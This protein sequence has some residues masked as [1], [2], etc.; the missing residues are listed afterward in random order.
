[1]EN[2]HDSVKFWCL[3]TC[4]VISP[5]TW[6]NNNK[7]GT[8]RDVSHTIYRK[9]TVQ[10]HFVLKRIKHLHYCTK[11]F[12]VRTAQRYYF[13][14]LHFNLP[15]SLRL[16]LENHQDTRSALYQQGMISIVSIRVLHYK[17]LLFMHNVLNGDWFDFICAVYST[18]V[19]I[20]NI[21]TATLQFLIATV[22]L[23]HIQL[24]KT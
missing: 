5:I 24:L 21:K 2:K 10:S 19:Q 23:L 22:L 9:Y 14:S 18:T 15:F 20:K 4:V 11:T 6:R 17:M 13:C 12:T 3:D 8:M 1:M 16:S 7:L